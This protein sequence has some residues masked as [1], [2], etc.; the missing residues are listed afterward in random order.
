MVRKDRKISSSDDGWIMSNMTGPVTP[1]TIK[2]R[3]IDTYSGAPIGAV[4][5]CVGN[6]ET[7]EY[8]TEVGEHT[9]DGYTHFAD[10][11][12]ASQ[13]RNLHSLIAPCGGPST[14]VVRQFHEA[15]IDVLPSV[16][17]NSHYDIAYD[18]R[19]MARSAA[20]TPAGSSAAP[21]S[22]TTS[23]RAPTTNIPVPAYMKKIIFELCEKFD[24]DGVELDYFRHPA[25][26]RIEEAYT[27]R[28][29]MTDFIRRIRQRLDE[30]GAQRGNDDDELDVHINGE[31]VPWDK[32]RVSQDGW[33]YTVF[34]GTV[35]HTTIATERVEGTLIQFDVTDLPIKKGK[36]SLRAPDRILNRLP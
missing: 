32:R 11:C 26:F 7:Y 4:S 30:V 2:K 36:G 5:W 35:Y 23:P 15:K 17:M 3:M 8:E 20:T 28:Y 34:D 21:P 1:Q 19:P 9:G 10:E 27:N 16:C 25:F 12:L 13:Q 29:L 14:E 31:P 6:S 24:V 33:G 18:S 22:N